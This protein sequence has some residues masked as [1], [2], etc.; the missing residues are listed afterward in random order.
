MDKGQDCLF[1]DLDII[2]L[3]EIQETTVFSDKV[4]KF[5]SYGWKQER[6]MVIT[7]KNLY[8][9]KKRTIKRKIL[10][11]NIKAITVST[12]EQS[13]EFVIHVPK[14]YDYRYTTPR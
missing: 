6:N 3:L 8:N 9:I 12:N 2:R 13:K 1:F 11:A 14:E 5:N 10:I 7:N 4:F